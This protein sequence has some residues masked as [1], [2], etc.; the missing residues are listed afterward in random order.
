VSLRKLTR[1]GAHPFVVVVVVDVVVV[2]VVAVVDVVVVDVVD[3]V[4]T[5][6]VSRSRHPQLEQSRLVSFRMISQYV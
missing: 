6:V 3:V 1:H 5:V 2:V 4:V